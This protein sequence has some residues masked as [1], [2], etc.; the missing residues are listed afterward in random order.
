MGKIDRQFANFFFRDFFPPHCFGLEL[1]GGGGFILA[2]VGCLH[3][4]IYLFFALLENSRI[5]VLVP[6]ILA[7]KALFDE[8]TN[9]RHKKKK[10]KHNR[11]AGVGGG[12]G[13]GGGIL[14]EKRF[15]T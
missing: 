13:R 5:S 10:K 14:R 1:S 7:G 12:E 6:L 8:D 11:R 3:I 2:Q 9:V 4:Y 15:S